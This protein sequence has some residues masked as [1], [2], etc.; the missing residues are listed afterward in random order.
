MFW[1]WSAPAIT[2][3]LAVAEPSAAEEI[4]AIITGGKGE[5]TK[6]SYEGCL[7]YHHVALPARITV[8]D[9][10]KLWYGSNP[11]YHVFAIAKIVPKDAGCSVYSQL[12]KTDGVDKIELATCEV[13]SP[14]K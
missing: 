2:C 11:K 13:T 5:L 9:K 1:G 4:T 14:T 7:L 10:V 12:V 3:F 8:G 6:C